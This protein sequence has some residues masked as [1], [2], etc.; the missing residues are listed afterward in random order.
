MLGRVDGAGK[1]YSWKDLLPA[2]LTLAA[3]PWLAAMLFA[4]FVGV[5]HYI[6]SYLEFG[7]MWR[8]YAGSSHY[9]LLLDLAV[10]IPLALTLLI[11]ALPLLS[12]R[13]VLFGDAHFAN[14]AEV[15][16]AGLRAGQ[17]VILGKLRGRLLRAQGQ[18]G[19]LLFAP[20][21]S[22][23]GVGFV[24]PNLLAWTGSAIVNDLKLENFEKTSG[25]RAA[26]GQGIVL[27]APL[28]PD[29]RSHA[30]NPLDF[31]SS[32][33]R[34]RVNDVQAI[35]AKLVVTPA[36]ADPMWSNEARV[37]LDGLILFLLDVGDGASLGAIYRMVL[38]VPNFADYLSWALKEYDG[39]LDPVS[40]MQFNGFLGKAAKEQSGV[41]STLKAS[42]SL[43]ANPL[44]DRATSTTDFDPRDLRRR[45]MTIFLGV[46]PRDI[47][48][49][50]PLLNIFV[51]QTVDSLLGRLPGADEPHQ[52]L[53]LLDE[54]TAL[55]R[56][57]NVEKGIAY[58]AGYNIVLAPVIQD[59]S[60][61]EEVYGQA[62]T[63]TFLSTANIRI[64]YAQNSLKTAKYLSEE[65]GF[66][67]IRTRSRSH[68]IADPWQGHVSESQARRELMLPHEI[69]EL[70]RRKLLL[71]VE[72][73]PPVKGEK[74][75]YYRDWRF[76]RLLRPPL[77]P[78]RLIPKLIEP[79]RMLAPE[80]ALTD[81][82][83]D[84]VLTAL[85]RP[86]NPHK[87]E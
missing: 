78:P 3:A 30:Y 85:D 18:L 5:P 77:E 11:A 27:F 68:R 45:R 25:A 21:R 48:R 55:G 28:D 59:L 43:F 81:Q 84:E 8:A 63:E 65:L 72:A 74:I 54:F 80:S 29:G 83:I 47:A 67:T 66:R 33:P 49:L 34:L 13:P 46:M 32:D 35:T 36:R 7:H 76:T 57:E 4:A 26:M 53:A 60:Q 61:L 38:S 73:A 20:P 62:V 52:V 50:S 39:R 19:V 58:F 1:G 82:E 2:L 22:G 79:P 69:R 71:L 12:R 56:L 44:I 16:A 10:A 86:G 14:E 87:Q 51:Q 24:I 75:R 42:L 15:R 40:V 6:P 31:V 41:L 9:R 70:D 64:A 17:G 37:L 23:K